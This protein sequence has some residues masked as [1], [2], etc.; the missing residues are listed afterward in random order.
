MSCEKKKTAELEITPREIIKWHKDSTSGNKL[1][2][3]WTVQASCD[4]SI[5][6]NACRRIAFRASGSVTMTNSARIFEVMRWE[7][8]NHRL[9]IVNTTQ[10]S[11]INNGEYKMK[12]E[13]GKDKITS[14]ELVEVKSSHCYLLTA[15]TLSE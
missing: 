6:C 12:Y 14:L 10:D 7:I 2:S 9:K 15:T 3:E 1:L 8:K 5:M 11:V 4:G 13:T